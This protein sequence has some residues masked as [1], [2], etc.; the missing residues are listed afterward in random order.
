MESYNIVETLM[1]FIEKW[2][3]AI[4]VLKHGLKQF[5]FSLFWTHYTRNAQA[6]FWSFFGCA[7]L[8]FCDLTSSSLPSA[9]H[10]TCYSGK[11]CSSTASLA[12][13][14]LS[15]KTLQRHLYLVLFSNKEP[16][17]RQMYKPPQRC[18]T[19]NVHAQHD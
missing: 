19:L 18:G 10:E 5:V 15:L 16:F 3:E 8:S 2:K 14:C 4:H 13:F 1:L 9:P 17:H 6:S 11:Y 7:P 12:D